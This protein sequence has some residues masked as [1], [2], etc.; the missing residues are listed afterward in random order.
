MSK[1]KIE[2]TGKTWNPVTGCD[3]VSAGCKFCYAEIMTRRLKAMRQEKYAAGFGTVVTHQKELNQ[4]YTW[5]K[6]QTVFVNS[7]SDL[8]HKDVP[9]SFIRDVFQVMN[10]LPQHTFQVLTK[11]SERLLKL[12]NSLNWMS[13][14]N[15]WQGVSIENEKVLHRL[16][17]LR[18]SNAAVKFLS[19]EPLIGPLKGLDL[20]GIDWVIVGGE[21][22]NKKTIRPI[23]PDWVIDIRDQCQAQ[24]IPF[25]FKQWGG[26]NKKK[27]G[28]ILEGK[29]YNEMPIQFTN[30]IL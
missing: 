29:Y 1:S 8:F 21:S 17:D 26:R 10:D 18:Y 5:K 30:A 20:S 2:W 19:L 23:N 9:V 24:N 16:E 13:N 7:M 22:G 27:A 25:F 3:K 4:P 28:R 14:S 15:I 6:P 11:R 12:S